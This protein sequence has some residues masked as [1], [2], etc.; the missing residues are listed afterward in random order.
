MPEWWNL[1]RSKSL[2]V[3]EWLS[4]L[5]EHRSLSWLKGGMGKMIPGYCICLSDISQVRFQV[6]DF[7]L[8][9]TGTIQKENYKRGGRKKKKKKSG[10]NTVFF[11]N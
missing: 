4:I 8:F 9:W 1:L 10:L 6:F 7:P 11:Q 5:T 3:H 2:S